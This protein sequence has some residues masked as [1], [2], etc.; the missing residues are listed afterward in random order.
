MRCDHNIEILYPCI[1]T[2]GKNIYTVTHKKHGITKAQETWDH[3]NTSQMKTSKSG[4]G[5]AC[6]DFCILIFA[7]HF[8]CR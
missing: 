3:M 4:R 2:C 6:D 1:L 5:K 8:Y 7:K